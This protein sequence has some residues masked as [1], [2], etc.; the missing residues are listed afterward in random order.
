MNYRLRDKKKKRLWWSAGLGAL[1]LVALLSG[2]F[3][4]TFADSMIALTSSKEDTASVSSSFFALFSSKAALQKDNDDLNK[5]LEDDDIRLADM[6]AILRENMNLKSALQM[7]QDQK[8]IQA[9]VL[10]KPP[11]APFDILFIG[12]GSDQGVKAGAPVMIGTFYIGNVTS[13]SSDTSEIQLLS[14]PSNKVNVFIGDKKIPAVASGTG[15]G[16]FI[17]TLPQ[18]VSINKADQVFVNLNSSIVPIGRVGAVISQPQSTLVTILFNLPIN[19]YEITYV[20][21]PL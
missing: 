12:A 18:G 6:D 20:E 3:S 19:L 17:V 16:N 15:G 21:I 10:S 1:V 11:F 7:K 13:V 9:A 14:S 8:R 2:F 5:K 4:R